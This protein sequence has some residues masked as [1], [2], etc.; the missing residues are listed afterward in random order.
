[1][2]I[3]IHSNTHFQHTH[4]YLIYGIQITLNHSGL[5]AALKIPGLASWQRPLKFWIRMRTGQRTSANQSR[6][7]NR[8]CPLTQPSNISCYLKTKLVIIGSWELYAQE[9]LLS[10]ILTAKMF[11]QT[12]P[13]IKL[14]KRIVNIIYSK[15]SV[16]VKGDN[17]LNP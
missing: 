16:Y 13:N 14:Q 2:T 8:K 1:M 10:K 11:F 5:C 12:R 17:H 3:S 15:A 4:L 6:Q 7:N 9:N